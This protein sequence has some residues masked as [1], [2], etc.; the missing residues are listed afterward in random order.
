MKKISLIFFTILAIATN[1]LNYAYAAEYKKVALVSSSTQYDEQLIPKINQVLTHHGYKVTDKYLDQIPSDFGYVN[2]DK[3]RASTL[4][5]AMLDDDIN[6]IWFIRGGGGGMNLLPY[7]YDRKEEI[8]LAKPKILVGFSDVTVLHSFVN[9]YLKWP[10][11]HGTLAAYSKEMKRPDD[12]SITVNDLEYTPLIKELMDK[13]VNYKNILPLNAAATG[14]EVYGELLGGNF[15]LVSA[16]LATK[17]QP[18]FSGKVLL[19]EDV[20]VSPRQLDRSLHQLRYMN[21]FNVSAII[22]G[23][24]YP[25]D[26]TDE[27]RLIYKSVIENFAS[28]FNKPVYY[29]PYVGHGRMNRPL[30]LGANVKLSCLA[31]AEYCSLVQAPKS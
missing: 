8:K 19:L 7:L 2:R 31:K 27:Q 28:K 11:I 5:N 13:G 25:I 10:T 1:I 23:Q 24:F 9:K 15:T 14:K 16:T 12:K 6:I 22:F 26:P 17:Y 3:S 21:D 20:G 29:Y 18:N 30:I 4:I